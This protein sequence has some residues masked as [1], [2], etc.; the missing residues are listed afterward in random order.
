MKLGF[1]SALSQQAFDEIISKMQGINIIPMFGT[2]LGLHRNGKLIEYDDDIDFI[3]SIHDR[4]N[5]I[6]RLV[7]YGFEIDLEV[8][9]NTTPYFLQA[10]REIGGA[11]ILIDFYF[12]EESEETDEI[13]LRWTISAAQRRE[14][15]L[16]IP[17]HY[18]FP[19]TQTE[20]NGNQVSIPAQP[21]T[22]CEAAYGKRW[23]TPLKKFSDY[24]C[25]IENHKIS[26]TYFN[27]RE[28]IAARD[29]IILQL[30][31][32]VSQLRNRSAIAEAEAAA[33]R[34]EAAASRE[35]AAA[36]REEAAACRAEAAAS[37][38]EAIASHEKA[39]ASHKMLT[40]LTEQV[41]RSV[42]N[43]RVVRWGRPRG[44]PLSEEALRHIIE[45]IVD[46]E[47]YLEANPDVAAAGVNPVQHFLNHGF[48]EGRA[49]QPSW[50]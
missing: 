31:E 50:K 38:E 12:W 44:A 28:R 3:A 25:T 48:K 7:N 5:I 16:Y 20:I 45:S 8:F 14:D 46:R 34:A 36:S 6:N 22:C 32:E 10:G 17:R 26:I 24:N 11:K 4:E 39:S 1:P 9:S 49:P 19:T 15:D 2:L 18:I 30:Q 33:C 29:A 13:I 47:W 40:A 21:T 35:E 42:I 27:T 43:S 37:R 23:R 41:M